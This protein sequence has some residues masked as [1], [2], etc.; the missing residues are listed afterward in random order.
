MAEEYSTALDQAVKRIDDLSVRVGA[1]ER[2]FSLIE[3]L[4]QNGKRERAFMVALL[5]GQLAMSGANF[6]KLFFQ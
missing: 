2:K 1:I 5:L 3:D 6:M 4:L